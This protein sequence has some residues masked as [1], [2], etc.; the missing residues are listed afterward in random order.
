MASSS[1]PSADL[2]SGDSLDRFVSRDPATDEAFETE[3]T[4]GAAV[5]GVK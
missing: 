2:T 1:R 3:V 4:G 5:A